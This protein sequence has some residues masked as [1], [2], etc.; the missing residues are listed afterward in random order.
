MRPG[1]TRHDC[2]IRASEHC[3]TGA[4]ARE[5]YIDSRQRPCVC[6][7]NCY[8]HE[9]TVRYNIR[10]EHLPGGRRGIWQTTGRITGERPPPAPPH[11]C[12]CRF[13]VATGA[14]T[15]IVRRKQSNSPKVPAS[16]DI[17]DA[18]VVSGPDEQ[19]FITVI[20]N[21]CRWRI[22]RC[23]TLSP[24]ILIEYWGWS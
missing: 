14:N 6:T 9:T 24:W 17:V 20:R 13:R 23:E 12:L 11:G 2:D 22:I 5:R 15:S 16:I 3:V 19:M 7:S 10:L 1:Y 4:E 18:T 8:V 21:Y